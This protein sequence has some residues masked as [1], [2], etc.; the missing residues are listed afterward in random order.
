MEELGFIE[1]RNVEGNKRRQHA[2]LTRKGLEL[3]DV[4]EPLALE[5][6]DAAMAGLSKKAQEDLRH[7][8]A[9]MIRNLENDEQDAAARGVRVPPTKGNTAN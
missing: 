3:R 9:V 7:A 8:L 6:N 2:F 5:V 4:L 1:R